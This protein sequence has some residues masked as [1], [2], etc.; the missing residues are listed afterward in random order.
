MLGRWRRMVKRTALA[1]AVIAVTAGLAEAQQRATCYNCPPEW[2]DWGTQLGPSRRNR[3]HRPPRQQEF[4]SDARATHRREGQPR[5]GHR[6]PRRQLRHPGQGCRRGRRLQAGQAGTRFPPGSRIRTGYW[7]TIHSGT[8]GLFVNV[9]ALAEAGTESL[10]GSHSSRSTR[11][12]SV[13]STPRAAFVGYV[14]AVAVN[15]AL[16]G[17]WTTSTG[18]RRTSRPAEERADRAEADL[19]RARAVGRDPDPVRLRLQRLPREVQ[20]QGERRVRHPAE[21]TLVVPYVMSL[22]KAGR[23]RHNGKKVLDFLLS[24]KGQAMWANAYL[25]PV[26]A[27][28]MSAE[29]EPRFLPR[30]EYARARTMDFR[31]MADVQKAFIKRYLNEVQ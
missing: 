8:L 4:R 21:G 11:A 3:H 23:T 29:A 9:D 24:D 15:Q 14:G 31:K 19:V 13:T 22:V 30:A 27:K 18:D 26:R 25:R 28:A 12:W 10:E 16:G 6:L 7:F 17:T 20:G 5:G 2:A 1:M